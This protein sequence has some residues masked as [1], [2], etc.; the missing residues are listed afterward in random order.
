MKPKKIVLC[1]FSLTSKVFALKGLLIEFLCHLGINMQ[2]TKVLFFIAGKMSGP[3]SNLTQPP[4]YSPGQNV[5]S[6]AASSMNQP[7][8]QMNRSPFPPQSSPVNSFMPPPSGT[9]G[10]SPSGI[11]PP[12]AQNY[13]Y[14]SS[15]QVPSMDLSIKSPMNFSNHSPLPPTSPK[16]SISPYP[17]RPN[18]IQNGPTLN[19]PFNNISP[20]PNMNNENFQVN[21]HNGPSALLPPQSTPLSNQ[22]RWTTPRLLPPP[23]SQNQKLSTSGVGSISPASPFAGTSPHSNIVDGKPVPNMSQVPSSGI[24][25]S[26]NSIVFVFP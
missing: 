4:V 20:G 17:E 6:P 11:A 7:P 16:N 18:Y 24:N 26:F 14:V 8:G 3:N 5:Y 2:G 10:L 12:I 15:P 9:P 13:N 19:S 22:N 25:V 21:G 23:D 1:I